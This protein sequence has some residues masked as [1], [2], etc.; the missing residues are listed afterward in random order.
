MDN[1][2]EAA[3]RQYYSNNP[4]G[5]LD[6][7]ALSR[8]L[9]YC[10]YYICKLAKRLGLTDKHR[11]KRNVARGE[12][13]QGWKGDNVSHLNVGRKRARNRF[14]LPAICDNCLSLPAKD[15]HHKDGNPLNNQRT[16]ISFLCRKCHMQEDGRLAIL[17]A[18][19][20][21][22]PLPPRPCSNCGSL[23]TRLWH[24]TCHA[25]NEYSRRHGVQR[26]VR[27]M[28][29]CGKE[30]SFTI[31]ERCADCQL[32]RR[33]ALHAVAERARRARSTV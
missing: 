27:R 15:R 13:N 26:P 25:C 7:T 29:E 30:I 5:D 17:V 11:S 33:R 28:C 24:G 14:R 21:R 16:N 20:A 18:G 23:V 3:I 19:A 6:L 32:I 2:L 9:G 4:S 8:R 10:R 22:E 12:D 1:N 31:S